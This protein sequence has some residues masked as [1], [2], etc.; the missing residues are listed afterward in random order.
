MNHIIDE[1]ESMNKAYLSLLFQLLNSPTYISTTRKGETISEMLNAGFILKD[2]TKCFATCRNMSL[3]YLDGELEFYLSGSPY[4]KD[5]TKHSKF[6]EKVTDDDRTVNSNYGKLLFYDRNHHNYT[7]FEYAKRMLLENP[8]SKKAVMVIY[9]K[10]NAHDSQDNPCTMFL[11]FFIREKKLHLIVKMRSSDI[12]YGLPYDVPFFVFVQYKMLHALERY[13]PSLRMGLYNHQSGSLHLYSRNASVAHSTLKRDREL[14]E[15]LSLTEEFLDFCE[16]IQ[17]ELFIKYIKT[18]VGE[19][20][21]D[22]E[23]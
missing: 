14:W 17:T 22:V 3:K 8:D 1:Y 20:K 9:S 10:E 7:Q 16:S 18:K 23:Y 6:W 12:W 19:G 15:N 5:I 4:L 21:G 2:P 13:Y 11:Q